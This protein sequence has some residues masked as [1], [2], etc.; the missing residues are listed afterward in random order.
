MQGMLVRGVTRNSKMRQAACYRSVN[1]RLPLGTPPPASAESKH[2]RAQHGCWPSHACN[3]SCCRQLS[4]SPVSEAAVLIM[5]T[6]S[7]SNSTEN[8]DNLILSF[9]WA[10]GAAAAAAAVTVHGLPAL[11]LRA[12]RSGRRCS[13]WAGLPRWKAAAGWATWR[14]EQ[15]LPAMA[16]CASTDVAMVLNVSDQAAA[17]QCAKARQHSLKGWNLY[18]I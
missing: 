6:D 4:R 12:V 14:Q 16:L 2:R 1:S 10:G 9:C 5:S 8:A 7:S 17:V 15:R 18:M 3:A 13:S 11:W